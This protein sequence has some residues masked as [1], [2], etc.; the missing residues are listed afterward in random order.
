MHQILPRRVVSLNL[1]VDTECSIALLAVDFHL[2]VGMIGTRT[3]RLWL[4]RKLRA[5]VLV[6]QTIVMMRVVASYT[7][8]GILGLAIFTSGIILTQ[9]TDDLLLQFPIA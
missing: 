5:F 3:Q 2:E 6:R 4:F 1:A 8:I 9:L 7:E